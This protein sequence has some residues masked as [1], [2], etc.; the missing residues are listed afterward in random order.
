MLKWSVCSGSS[1]VVPQEGVEESDDGGEDIEEENVGTVSGWPRRYHGSDPLAATCRGKLQ[2]KRA[3]LNVEINKALMLR[4]GAENLYKVSV[5]AKTRENVSLEL[6]FVNS[7]LQLLKEKLAELNSAVEIYQDQEKEWLGMPMI[8]LGLKE[9]TEL[10]PGEAIK[11]FIESH[12]Y[13]DGEDYEDQVTELGNLRQAMRTPTRDSHGISLL[14]QYYNQLHFLE[15]RFFTQDSDSCR[16]FFQWYDSLTGIPSTQT[17]VAYEK[18]CI[19][20]NIGALYTQIGARQDRTT[21]TGLDSAV[22]SFMRAAGAFEFIK[23]SFN[24][25]PSSDLGTHCLRVVVQLMLGQAREC[26]LEKTVLG[27]V[28]GLDQVMEVSQEAA[29]VS[30]TYDEVV[31]SAEDTGVKEVLPC[32]W[33]CLLRVKR[34]HYRAMADYYVAYGLAKHQG[35]ISLKTAETFQFLFDLEDLSGTTKPTLPKTEKQRNHLGKAHLREAL[36]AHE[37][38][39][40]INRMCQ[41]MKRK[42]PLQRVLNKS[43]EKSLTLYEDLEEED[44]FEELLEPPPVLPSTKF[45]L[46]LSFP[47]SS[48]PPSTDIFHCLGP[49]SVFSAK[50]H[51]TPPRT[52]VLRLKAG[53]G[54]GLSVRGAAPVVVAGVEQGSLAEVAGV[55]Q[56]D[57]VVKVG[58][59]DVK[60]A[61]HDE[62]VDKIRESGRSL[63]I[64]VVTPLKAWVSNRRGN[65][66]KSCLAIPSTTIGLFSTTTSRC[67]FSSGSSSISSDSVS[68]DLSIPRTKKRSWSLLKMKNKEK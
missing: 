14:F 55:R 26:L 48:S 42:E 30:A 8:P 24:N 19:L 9:T 41:E 47:S 66:I 50:H 39:L 1:P 35:E 31:R 20:F 38:A 34:E 10:D 16:L 44:D 28:E 65:S 46:S 49:E 62:V 64:T 4:S 67:S 43:H 25:A 58:E 40:R 6:R 56:G 3:K 27:E 36:L 57:Y 59:S 22:D 7:S 11:T 63:I 21:E 13:E 51:W 52:A 29:H 5:D 60:W 45:Q 12:Y 32:A 37:E 61:T 15:R 33:L 17:T 68:G 2:S 23:E 54:Y 18:A 53:E